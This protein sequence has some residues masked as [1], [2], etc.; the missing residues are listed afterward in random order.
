[1]HHRKD[2]EAIIAFQKKMA[3]ESENLEAQQTYKALWMDDQ[4]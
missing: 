3:L 4:L 1:M 2:L